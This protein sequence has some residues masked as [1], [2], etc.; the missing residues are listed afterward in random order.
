MPSGVTIRGA[1][2]KLKYVTILFRYHPSCRPVSFPLR[3][4]MAVEPFGTIGQFT[5]MFVG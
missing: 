1:S 5:I 3:R 4:C 2:T